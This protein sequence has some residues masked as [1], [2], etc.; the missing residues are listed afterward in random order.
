MVLEVRTRMVQE[1][2]RTDVGSFADEELRLRDETLKRTASD[3]NESN[4][5]FDPV[6]APMLGGMVNAEGEFRVEPPSGKDIDQETLEHRNRTLRDTA[7]DTNPRQKR[8]D[9]I[10]SPDRGGMR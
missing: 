5:T 3:S 4:K 6:K 1:Q 10:L 8:V 9:Q 7:S 2:R